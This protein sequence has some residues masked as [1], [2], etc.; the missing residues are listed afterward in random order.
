MVLGA[1]GPLLGYS[2][3]RG[4]WP[5]QL[6][7]AQVVFDPKPGDGPKTA[8]DLRALTVLSASRRVASC[9]SGTIPGAPGRFAAADL[10]PALRARH[11]RHRTSLSASICPNSLTPSSGGLM[12]GLATELCL[13]PKIL[14]TIL[15][16]LLEAQEAA[17]HSGGD[18]FPGSGFPLRVVSHKVTPLLFCGRT[19]RLSS[20]LRGFRLLE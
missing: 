13:P 2:F 5:T 15:A 18:T 16:F 9:S 4:C 14:D 10:V 3:Q 1:S 8:S 6:L 7:Q 20:F 12:K 19:S 17:S 11:S